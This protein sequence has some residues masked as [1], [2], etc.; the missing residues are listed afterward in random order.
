MTILRAITLSFPIEYR[1]MAVDRG[2]SDGTQDIGA[3]GY[4]F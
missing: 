3:G 4:D 2:N 1:M